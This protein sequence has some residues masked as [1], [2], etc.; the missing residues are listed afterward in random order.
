MTIQSFAFIIGLL[1]Y[2][3]EGFYH[4]TYRYRVRAVEVFIDA[5]ARLLAYKRLFSSPR[6]DYSGN[7]CDVF[8]ALV[9]TGR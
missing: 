5:S 2:P 1:D 3:E 8:V 7:D 6:I 9:T 4:S